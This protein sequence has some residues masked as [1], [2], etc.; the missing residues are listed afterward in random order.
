[1]IGVVA[2]HPSDDSYHCYLHGY[3]TSRLMKLGEDPTSEGLPI[4][5]AGTQVDGIVLSLTPNSHSMNYRSAVLQGVATILNDHEERL[6]A[7]EQITNSVLPGRWDNTRIPP[8]NVELTST[9]IMK[10]RVTAASGKIRE[11]MPHD[12]RKDMKRE[13]ILNCV[14]TGVVPVSTN[15]GEPVPGPYNRVPNIPEH[16]KGFV[17]GRNESGKNFAAKRATVEKGKKLKG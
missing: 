17:N 7:M 16:V 1:M 9:K 4:C 6:W 2:K 5:V 13:E 14:W 12:D 11:G 15:Y 10:V 3:T 8:D